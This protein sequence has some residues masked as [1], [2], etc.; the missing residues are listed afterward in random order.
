MGSNNCTDRIDWLPG[1]TSM[2]S[3]PNIRDGCFHLQCGIGCPHLT[4]HHSQLL[5]STRLTVYIKFQGQL[6]INYLAFF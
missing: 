2:N 5:S 6:Q 3:H 4:P 1:A